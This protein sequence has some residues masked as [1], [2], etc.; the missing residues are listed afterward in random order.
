MLYRGHMNFIFFLAFAALFVLFF[1][2]RGRVAEL[3]ERVKRGSEQPVLPPV[4]RQEEMTVPALVSQPVQVSQPTEV[5]S[6]WVDQFERW[7]KEDWLLKLGALLILIGFGWLASYAF[8]NNWIGPMGRILIGVFAGVAILVFGWLRM[9][10]QVHQGSVFL[11]LGSTTI[12]LT[13][14]AAREL[15]DFF[16]PTSALVVMFLSTAFVGFA[17]VKFNSRSLSL[18]SLIL[19][20]IAPLLT[21]TPTPDYAQLF[22]YLLVVTLGTLW[23]MVLTKQRILTAAALIIMGFYSLPHWI[24]TAPAY[25]ESLLWFASAFTIVFCAANALSLWKREKTDDL[26]LDLAT[27]S[28]IGVFL[29]TWVLTAA[30]DDWKNSLLTLWMIVFVIGAYFVYK[31]SAR[32][33]PVYVYAGVGVAL[34]G[35]A[36]AVEL[37]GASLVIAYT[38][39]AVVITLIAYLLTLNVRSTERVSLLLLIP[40][41]LSMKSMGATVWKYQ[42]FNEHFF[43]LLLLALI[44]LA[45]GLFFMEWARV[46]EQ[47][48]ASETAVFAL[49]AGSVYADIL[50]WLWTHAAFTN[51]DMAV[52][53]SLVCYTLTG[54]LAYVIGK[55]H[56]K[57]GL[58]IYGGVVLGLVVL[59]LLIVDIWQMDLMGRIITFF[60]I[61]ILLMSTAFYGRTSGLAKKE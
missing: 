56:A 55:T 16:T 20:G 3:E 38:I 29:L 26:T 12:L 7:V 35:A 1:Q 19:A 52:T 17:S 59:R 13:L 57:K 49:I 54:L 34:L 58:F 44:L 36:T 53:I 41:A 28:G 24:G 32:R 23:I 39:E 48:P 10:K 60:A 5:E 33:E 37:S 11:V 8:L 45:L 47:R 50:L 21:N 51:Q 15:Y 18:A 40:M 2:L 6:T 25:Q 27:A 31:L 43:V 30:P 42:A 9:K 46:K 4:Q 61:G 14:F 22:L